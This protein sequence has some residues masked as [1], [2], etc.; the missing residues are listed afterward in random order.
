MRAQVDLYKLIQ[1]NQRVPEHSLYDSEG[2]DRTALVQSLSIPGLMST[3]RQRPVWPTYTD[4]ELKASIPSGT[5]FR[6]KVRV[7]WT[8]NG[9]L[10]GGD[11]CK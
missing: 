4:A 6:P 8:V 5:P 7:M 2:I 9:E 3:Q 10:R 1:G 11:G